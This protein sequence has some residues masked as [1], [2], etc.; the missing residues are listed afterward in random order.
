MNYSNGKVSL[1]QFFTKLSLRYNRVI[2]SVRLWKEERLSQNP[3]RK[4]GI[5]RMKYLLLI[6]FLSPSCKIYSLRLMSVTFSALHLRCIQNCTRDFVPRGGKWVAPIFAAR[7]EKLSW[8]IRDTCVLRYLCPGSYFGLIR[9]T[10]PRRES[11]LSRRV[12]QPVRTSTICPRIDNSPR[13]N[14]HPEC[15]AKH[16]KLLY[17]FKISV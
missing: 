16:T 6:F 4:R 9:L 10:I 8:Y 11:I 15:M 5:D 17:I 12:H 7:K 1:S 2:I 3:F 13:V 14:F